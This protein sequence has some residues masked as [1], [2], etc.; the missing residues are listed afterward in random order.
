MVR[1]LNAVTA[2]TKKQRKR[3]KRR[4]PAIINTS[5]TGFA[6][7]SNSSYYKSI[8]GFENE[9]FYI[10]THKKLA[11]PPLRFDYT[12]VSYGNVYSPNI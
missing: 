4:Q 1:C 5:N 9:N 7:C 6:C 2:N 10:A 11:D 8:S 3:Q 12:H